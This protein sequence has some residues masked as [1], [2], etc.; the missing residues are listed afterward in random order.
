MD[1]ARSVTSL[2]FGS[3]CASTVERSDVGLNSLTISFHKSRARSELRD[4]HV[5][6][7]SNAEEK[8]QTRSKL[9]DIESSR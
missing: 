2:R 9:V 4:F 5:E 3:V 6:V 1:L 8:G 7:H